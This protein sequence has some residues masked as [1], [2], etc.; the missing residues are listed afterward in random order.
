MNSSDKSNPNPNSN[1][2]KNPTAVQQANGD[3][4]DNGTSPRYIGCFHKS[5]P[6]NDYG[7]VDENEFRKLRDAGINRA[8]ASAKYDEVEGGS[9]D[10]DRFVN[11]VAGLGL[12]RLAPPFYSLAMKPAP[13]VLSASTA[14]EMVELY[15]MALLRDASFSEFRNSAKAAEAAVDISK[16]F[17]VAFADASDA[18]HLVAGRD[19]PAEFTTQ[20]LFRSGLPGEETGPYVSQFFLKNV[21]YGAQFID[22][23]VVPYKEKEDYL[24]DYHSWIYAQNFAKDSSGRGYGTARPNRLAFCRPILT[25][26]DLATFVNQD[27]LH[28]A[29]FNAALILSSE[30]YPSLVADT[31]PSGHGFPYPS[32]RQGG[33]VTFGGPHLLT[34]VSEVAAR[35][36]KVVWHQKWQVHLRLRPEAYG[37][38][39]HMQLSGPPCKSAKPYG[40]HSVVLNSAALAEI[41]AKYQGN[42]FLPMPFPSGSPNHPAYGAGHATV[43]G[44]CVTVLKA[45]FKGDAP[46]ADPVDLIPAES[47]YPIDMPAY[48]SRNMP[49]LPTLLGTTLTVEGELNKIASNV[50]LGRSLGGVHWRSDNTRSLRLG[51]DIA[52]VVLARELR[53]LAERSANQHFPSFEFNNFD[54]EKVVI[55]A[56]GVTVGGVPRY[57]DFL[58]D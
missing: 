26:R 10:S 24:T 51:E 11:P 55:T 35:A 43:A 12:D 28:Q 17:D 46:I 50:A 6:H 32:K 13:K 58:K 1:C 20:N 7:E 31:S 29:Y 3:K 21:Y 8:K 19:A 4:E 25:P 39:V 56:S 45:W 41:R 40:L 57:S 9:T 30:G 16:A 5:L 38:L 27:A 33:F 48:R 47:Y 53:D 34:L 15:W 2:F 14:A 52:I 36:M 22:Q 49:G 37:G 42:A 54:G 18:G 44:A 23:R